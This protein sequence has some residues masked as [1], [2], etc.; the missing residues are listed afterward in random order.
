MSFS[1]RERRRVAIDE[2]EPTMTEQCHKDRCDMHNIM[3]Q[4]EKTG[5]IEH[6]SRYA[7]KYMDMPNA[8]SFHEAMNTIAKAESMFETVPA[9][10]RAKFH[11]D[12]AEYIEFMQDP[13]NY[14]AIKEMG[15]DPSHLPEPERPVERPQ[16]PP[17]LPANE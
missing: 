14:D 13:K 11:N 4:F 5:L 3:R 12:P 9:K 2:F 8:P 15:L 10:I 1:V 6:T 16:E 17:E 7:G